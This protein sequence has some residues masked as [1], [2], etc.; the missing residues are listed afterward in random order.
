MPEAAKGILTHEERVSAGARVCDPQDLCP[1][2]RL[3]NCMSGLLKTRIFLAGHRPALR[4]LAPGGPNFASI[5]SVS[6]PPKPRLSRDPPNNLDVPPSLGREQ[7]PPGL[8]Q[9]KIEDAKLGVSRLEMSADIYRIAMSQDLRSSSPSGWLIS[10]P[11]SLRSEWEK[12][13][14]NVEDDRQRR[15]ELESYLDKGPR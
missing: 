2:V 1:C 15:T 11:E 7:T 9:P 8:R 6:Q 3:S 14:I 12:S 10:F 13:F 4:R 5:S